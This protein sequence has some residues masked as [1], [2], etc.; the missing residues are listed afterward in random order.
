MSKNPYRKTF[1]ILY[2]EFALPLTK[3]IIKRT[4]GN[5]DLVDEVFSRT[6]EAS[7]KGYKTFKHKSSFFTWICRIALNK[8]ADYYREQI[9]SRSGIFVPLIEGITEPSHEP[10]HEEKLALDELRSS[11]RDCINLLPYKYRQLIY[12][13]YWKEL[14]YE[15]ISKILG[16]SERSIEGRLYRARHE[17]S[18][19]FIDKDL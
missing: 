9:N 15:Q 10:R 8:I 2:K 6:I 1:E 12:L 16:A 11:V 5:Q 4:G 7:F 13:R 14:T 18:K 19:I 17:L 3:F